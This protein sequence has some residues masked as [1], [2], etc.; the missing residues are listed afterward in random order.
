MA[1]HLA[2]TPTHPPP[3][4]VSACGDGSIKVWDLAAPPHANP[5]RSYEEHTHEVGGWV[6]RV[7]GWVWGGGDGDASCCAP[8][9]PPPAHPPLPPPPPP[10][11]HPPRSPPLPQVY[12]LHWNQVRRDTFLSGSWDDTVKL[13]SLGAP[14]SLRT[15]GEHTYCVYAAQWNPRQVGGLSRANTMLP[16]RMC[17]CLVGG[18]AGGWV[19]GLAALVC[20]ATTPRPP[21]PL[22]PPLPLQ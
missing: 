20:V 21:R 8:P 2:H 11:P 19:G 3:M 13:W 15:F 18:L 4:Q 10:H 5:L 6:G 14:A 12:S 7:G 9:P 17:V 22:L 16:T 1:S